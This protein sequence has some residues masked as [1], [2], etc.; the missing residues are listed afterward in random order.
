MEEIIDAAK[1][2]GIHDII[3][4]LKDGYD[5]LYEKAE[6]SQGQM[7]LLQVARAVVSDP[8]IM[9]LDEMTANLDSNT[10]K[11]ILNALLNASKGRTVISISH[12]LMEGSMAHSLYTLE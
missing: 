8:E 4:L 11:N 7:Q 6:L 2:A 10:E 9:L 12:R 3:M 5:T 1:I